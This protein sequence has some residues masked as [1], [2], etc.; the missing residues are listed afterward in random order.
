MSI[1]RYADQFMQCALDVSG[2]DLQ[3]IL[4]TEQILSSAR[5]DEAD[6]RAI[7]SSLLSRGL[8]TRVVDQ[9]DG[10]SPLIRLTAGGLEKACQLR[11]DSES[12][13]KRETHLHN[14]LVRW[15]YQNAPAGGWASLQLFALDEAWWFCGT[16]VTWDEVNA[17]V[18]YLAE[19]GLLR[20]QQTPGYTDIAPTAMGT[21][22]AHGPTT[23]RTF[24]NNQQAPGP[25]I[26]NNIGSMF[27][28]GD[29]TNSAISTGSGNALTNN[30]VAPAA[31]SAL[32]TQLREL[33]P[34]LE[35]PEQDA[36]DLAGEIDSLEREGTDPGRGARIW[37]SI[38]RMI[39]PALV[40]AGTDQGLQATIAAGSALFG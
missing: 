33:A 27:F 7:I 39:A 34:S 2:G 5:L 25:S 28:N 37:R 29:I 20:V 14:M 40:T 16:Q 26:T 3:E 12:K 31:L 4:N 24:M 17:A 35:L 6:E 18:T 15:A 21:D 9:A 38:R 23:L 30:G 11:T 22:F 13:A 19:R 1:E 36:Q 10:S 8:V 32:V